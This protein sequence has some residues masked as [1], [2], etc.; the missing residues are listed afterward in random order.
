MFPNLVVIGAAKCG[1]TS[2]HRYL[3]RHPDIGM[4]HP[5]EPRHFVRA[6]WEARLGEQRLFDRMGST[7]RGES[8][9]DYTKFPL[10]Q[11]IPRRIH[12]VIPDAKLIYVVGD[13]VRRIV[14]QYVEAQR[15]GTTT[16]AE[17][18]LAAVTSAMCPAR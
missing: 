18:G 14:A 8:S 1:T 15:A 7:I 6:D 10:W 13:P 4:S 2:L 9:T 17:H 16:W 12:W 11:D 5:K 3:G